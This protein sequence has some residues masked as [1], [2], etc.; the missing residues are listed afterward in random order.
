MELVLTKNDLNQVAVAWD[1]QPSHTF[2]L[3]D[4]LPQQQADQLV[5]ANPIETGMRLFAAL[6]G[7][8]HGPR[9]LDQAPQAHPA[10]D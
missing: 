4:L 9:R 10:C 7:R 8:Q 6:R 1:G 2:P 5:L 3:S